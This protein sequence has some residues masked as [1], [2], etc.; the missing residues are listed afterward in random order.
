MSTRFP[1]AELSDV[2]GDVRRAILEVQ[3]KSGFVPQVFLLLARRPA[4]FRAFFAY[5]DALMEREGSSL[6]KGD[7]EMIVVSISGANRCTY[8]VVAHGALL[9]IFERKPLVADQVAVNHHTADI[10]SRQRAML[11][12]AHK[13]NTHSHEVDDADFATLHRHGFND[14]DAW[15]IASI[16]AFFGLSNRI[17]SVTR[18]M[19]NPEFYLMGRVPR[20]PS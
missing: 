20:S 7:R 10:S 2:P 13:V 8:C 14:E 4:E 19:P 9:R 5:H 15:D 11:D 6:T 16:T 1:D 17:A 12:F 18:T 3:E